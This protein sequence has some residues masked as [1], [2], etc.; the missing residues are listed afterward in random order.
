M[1]SVRNTRHGDETRVGHMVYVLGRVHQTGVV[2]TE[3]RPAIVILK[4]VRD[5]VGGSGL[6]VCDGY[7]GNFC[8]KNDSKFRFGGF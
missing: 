8:L 7:F 6:V 4:D 2:F 3:R 1:S 5:R